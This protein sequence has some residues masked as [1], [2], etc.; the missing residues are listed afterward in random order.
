MPNEASMPEHVRAT[1][2]R[3]R[4]TIRPDETFEI[5]QSGIPSS[6]EASLHDQRATL[7]VKRI[8]DRPVSQSSEGTI[9]QNLPLELERKADGTVS[10]TDPGGFYREPVTLRRK[11]GDR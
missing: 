4:L 6:G 3:V 2:T 5:E 11:Q 1:V 7:Y 8:F 9:K 10:F